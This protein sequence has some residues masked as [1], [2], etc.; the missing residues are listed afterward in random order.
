MKTFQKRFAIQLLVF[1]V[2]VY[3]LM[4]LIFTKYSIADLPLIAMIGLLF[5]I[6]TGSFI[7]VTDTKEKRP[8]AFVYSYMAITVGR[9]LVC[10]AFVFIYALTHRQYARSF[11]GAFFVL[12]FIY[13]IIEVRAL[14]SYFKK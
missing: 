1:S 3:G 13:T 8:G 14:Y 5:A 7:I 11:A 12:Y 2:A 10:G 6:N 9:L 4:F